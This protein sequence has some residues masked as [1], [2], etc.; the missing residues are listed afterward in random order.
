[1]M[2]GESG[3]SETGRVYQYYRCVHT[4]KVKTC[5]KK[6]VRK[7]W[8]EDLVVEEAL[9]VLND[10]EIVEQLADRLYEMQGEEGTYLQSLRRAHAEAEKSL[11][12]VMRAIEQ[13]IIT[14]TTK[15]RLTE[16]EA[17]KKRLEGEI[18]SEQFRH[19]RMSRDEIVFG[20][21]RF[22]SLD[23]T[24]HEGRQ[25]LI[26]GFINSVFLYDDRIV[27]N[28]NGTREARTLTLEE[29]KSSGSADKPQPRNPV[30][31]KGTWDFCFIGGNCA[32]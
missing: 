16:L 21:E 10:R 15:A 25:K 3:H 18:G 32:E 12:N 17:D 24:T 5:S 30:Y 1:M 19:P 27:L 11:A 23:V 28:F 31:P 2:V 4:K 7:D 8:I 9:R 13:G 6:P 22:A 20:I 29:V 14:E 26:D